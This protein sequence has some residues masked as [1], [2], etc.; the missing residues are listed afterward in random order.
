MTVFI[1]NKGGHDYSDAQRFGELVYITS[2]TINTFDLNHFRDQAYAAMFLATP[3]DYVLISGPSSTCAITVA[4]MAAKFG[5]VNLLIYQRSKYVHKHVQLC[6]S[7]ESGNETIRQH[8]D[9]RS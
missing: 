1:P 7:M 8:K 9:E 6:A 5:R 2:G 4:I 3:D